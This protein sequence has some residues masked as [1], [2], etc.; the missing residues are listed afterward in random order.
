MGY[1]RRI[2]RESKKE[3]LQKTIDDCDKSLSQS[4]FQRDY[5]NYL[6]KKEIA[7]REIKELG[8]D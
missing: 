2:W 1:I 8:K 3:E 7:K 6:I 4:F 5:C